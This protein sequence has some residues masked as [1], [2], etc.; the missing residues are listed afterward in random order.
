VTEFGGVPTRGASDLLN[1]LGLLRIGA[2]AM[3]TVMRDGKAM[4]VRAPMTERERA[5]SK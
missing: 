2:V 4:T 5:R 3:L 1:R